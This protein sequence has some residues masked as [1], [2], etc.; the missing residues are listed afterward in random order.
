MIDSSTLILVA[1][2]SILD[3]FIDNTKMKITIT[4]AIQTECTRKKTFDA[5]MIRK[6]ITEKKMD[7]TQVTNSAL[8][9][10][11][12]VDFRFGFGEAEII[13][14]AIEKNA[15]VISDDK[16][17]I[18]ACRVLRLQFMTAP[19]ILVQ[20]YKKKKISADDVRAKIEKLFYYGRYSETV[21]QKIR[22]DLQ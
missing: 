19:N 17:A 4:P 10:K 20:L 9:R 11:L 7:I 22:E 8:V 16:K 21:K 2:I 6:R 15:I 1:K 18:N 14:A 3:K 5:E 12:I 13:A